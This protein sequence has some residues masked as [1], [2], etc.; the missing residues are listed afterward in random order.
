MMKFMAEAA[1]RVVRASGLLPRAVALLLAAGVLCSTPGWAADDAPAAQAGP[2]PV[3]LSSAD[4]QA[5]AQREEQARAELAQAQAAKD[6][7]DTAQ[8]E[9]HFRQSIELASSPEA[10]LGLI[11]VLQKQPER[12]REVERLW[13]NALA[14][15]PQAPQ[16]LWANANR[17]Y[18]A[19]QYKPALEAF[20]RACAADPGNKYIEFQ[21]GLCHIMAGNL[22]PGIEMSRQAITGD[23]WQFRVE[24]LAEIVQQQAGRER[25]KLIWQEYA[26]QHPDDAELLSRYAQFVSKTDPQ[27]AVSLLRHCVELEPQLP[28]NYDYLALAL[29]GTGQPELAMEAIAQAISL[30]PASWRYSLQAQLLLLAQQ[31][32]PALDSLKHSTAQ[33]PDDVTLTNYYGCTLQCLGR[34]AE[35]QRYLADAAQRLNSSTLYAAAGAAAVRSGDTAAAA[36]A[37]TQYAKLDPATAA[38]DTGYLGFMLAGQNSAA[39]IELALSAL[40]TADPEHTS[41]ILD[42]LSRS[43]AT[44][45]TADSVFA[46]L[47]AKYPRSAPVYNAYAQALLK[48]KAWDTTLSVVR[49]GQNDCGDDYELALLEAHCVWQMQGAQDALPLAKKLILRQEADAD[50]YSQLANLYAAME[51]WDSVVRTANAG[52][53]SCGAD[54]YLLAGLV[55]AYEQSGQDAELVN[56]LTQPEYATAEYAARDL[57]LGEAYLRLNNIPKAVAHLQRLTDL[58]PTLGWA[59]I[60]LARA[61]YF[62]GDLNAARQ[63]LARAVAAKYDA[64]SLYVWL[65]LVQLS[66]GEAEAAAA[67][68]AKVTAEAGAMRSDLAWRALGLARLAQQAGEL[69]EALERLDEAAAYNAGDRALD[70]QISTLHEE[71]EQ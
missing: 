7:G 44:A 29:M 28:G 54:P 71:L 62:A 4:D 9:A 20:S 47:I 2:A 30:E 53:K 17:L 64:P 26:T 24:Q 59:C 41:E 42:A 32:E 3:V 57:K 36:A 46:Q 33:Y 43:C 68:F 23:Y 27:L 35:A 52:L 56:L 21:A 58:Y 11:A 22:E 1:G 14:Q 48:A 10:I 70:A 65:G 6:A 8:A 18:N 13:R 63:A 55:Q 69:A 49:R 5:Q 38:R 66:G 60:E 25:A 67:S 19:G 51:D 34:V 12:E 31:Y 15:F 45:A 37:Y 16:V 61:Q 39:T 50:A 40:S